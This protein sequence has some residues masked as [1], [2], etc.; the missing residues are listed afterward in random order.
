ME[1]KIRINWSAGNIAAMLSGN[2]LFA[3]TLKVFLLPARLASGG[4]TG[5]ALAVHSM[6][7]VPVS[8]VLLLVNISMLLVGLFALGKSFAATTLASTFFLPMALELFERLLGDFVLTEDLLLCA[9]FA[10]LGVGVSLGLVLR[11]GAS[12]G[13][14]DIPPLILQR[15]FRIPVSV[16]LYSF[17]VIILLLQFP[18]H[19]AEDILYSILF[20]MVTAFTL[21]R[22]LMIGTVQ[23]EVKI[24]SDKPLL[25]RDAIL[26]QLD[27]GVTLLDAEGGYRHGRTQM[28]LSVLSNRELFRLQRIVRGIDP[29]CFMVVTR[30]SEVR[31]RGFT[32]DKHA[33]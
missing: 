22:M 7:G 19:E 11:T 32:M 12:T 2:V 23:T 4:G 18:Q 3:L 28:V 10:G 26:Y 24:V 30:V 8:G 27:R 15:Y 21:D 33:P 14:M 5:I 17:D 20:S 13:G 25:L 29:G 6:T 31:G 9:L 1:E 16:S